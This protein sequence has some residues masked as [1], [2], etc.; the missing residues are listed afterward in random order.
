MSS[1]PS[2]AS[3]ED[4]SRWQQRKAMKV[5]MYAM[6][7]E[8]RGDVASRRM[9]AQSAKYVPQVQNWKGEA[10]GLASTK[11]GGRQDPSKTRISASSG[12]GELYYGQK[13]KFNTDLP[14]EDPS[15]FLNRRKPQ[16]SSSSL[17]AAKDA[18][19]AAAEQARAAKKEAE[20]KRREIKQAKDKKRKASRVRIRA[21]HGALC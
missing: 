13:R 8:Q 2:G 9:Q 6:S 20:R 4:V 10:W 7:D 21:R 18:E 16:P 1:A 17:R 3:G 11:V 15:S 5:M 12:S 14:P 19:R